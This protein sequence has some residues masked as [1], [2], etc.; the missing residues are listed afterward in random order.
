ML[1]LGVLVVLGRRLDHR[2]DMAFIAQ[3]QEMDPAWRLQG[4][5]FEKMKCIDEN[6][7]RLRVV[8]WLWQA[9]G[10]AVM[11]AV[12]ATANYVRSL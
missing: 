4:L 2:P 3:L 5:I 6:E 10:A 1:D 12:G 11:V 9:H 8:E 7:D